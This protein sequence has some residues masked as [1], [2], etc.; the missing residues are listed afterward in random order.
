VPK[1]TDW[2]YLFDI[3]TAGVGPG[4]D[5]VFSAAMLDRNRTLFD[6]A[7]DLGGTRYPIGSLEFSKQDWR[8]H[9][10][11]SYKTFKR[12]KRRYDPSGILTPGPGIF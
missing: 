8:E 12:L 9:Y 3:L 11:R 2:I 10:G 6:Q 5:P 1:H 7:R 4:D